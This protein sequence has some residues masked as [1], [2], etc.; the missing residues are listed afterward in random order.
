MKD[1]LKNKRLVFPLVII[2]VVIVIA[3][4]VFILI[5]K[6]ANS[7]DKVSTIKLGN[8]TGNNATTNVTNASDENTTDNT[9]DNTSNNTLNSTSGDDFEFDGDQFYLDAVESFMAGLMDEDD[10]QK[11]VDDHVDVKAYLAAYLVNGDD[12]EFLDEYSGIDDDDSKIEQVG[13]KFLD[14]VSSDEYEIKS[15]SDPKESGDDESITRITVTLKSDSETKKYRMVFYDDIVI[16]ICDENGDSV[17][18]LND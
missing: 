14:L 6:G 3:I 7:S 5:G 13:E 18:D 8:S 9:T 16:Y 1:L 15:I 17:I 4:V 10:M 12:A 11:F 2:L